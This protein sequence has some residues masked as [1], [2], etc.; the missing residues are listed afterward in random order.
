M[1]DILPRTNTEDSYCGQQNFIN[2]LRRVRAADNFTTL[3]TSHALRACPALILRFQ[4]CY[5]VRA[6][7]HRRERKS[8]TAQTDKGLFKL[9]NNRCITFHLATILLKISL[10][11]YNIGV[12]PISLVPAIW[13]P[14]STY[15]SS[16]LVKPLIMDFIT[17]LLCT[18]NFT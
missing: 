1:V 18:L 9:K 4:V 16:K 12:N 17:F 14:Q 3:F 5:A 8:F 7:Y 13:N 11:R 2:S 10:K 15:Y 6:L